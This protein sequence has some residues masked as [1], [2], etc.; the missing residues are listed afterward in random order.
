MNLSAGGERL[1]HRV[2]IRVDRTLGCSSQGDIEFESIDG[3]AFEVGNFKIQQFQLHGDAQ[4]A[5]EAFRGVYPGVKVF[6][7]AGLSMLEAC[8]KGVCVRIF[9]ITPPHV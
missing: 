1:V 4:E 8:R 3:G 7:F 9:N 5:K 2:Q 6:V